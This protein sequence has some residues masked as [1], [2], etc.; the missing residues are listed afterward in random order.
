VRTLASGV[1]M[2]AMNKIQ[3]WT[4][5]LAIALSGV[6]LAP[7]A[8]HA[9]GDCGSCDRRPYGDYCDGPRWGRYGAKDPVRTA[10]EA[11]KRLE[12]FFA[13]DDATVGKITNHDTYY[14][15]EIHD[16]DRDLVDRVIIDKRTGRIRSIL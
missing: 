1:A 12:R 15:A 10:E 13:E 11:R 14:E 9:Q 16:G 6:A 5:A 4:L 7:Q 3:G 8:V 2:N